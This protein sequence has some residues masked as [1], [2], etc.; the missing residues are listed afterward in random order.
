MS[1]MKSKILIL[2]IFLMVLWIIGIILHDVSDVG[3]RNKYTYHDFVFPVLLLGILFL[4]RS[5]QTNRRTSESSKKPSTLIYVLG[6]IACGAIFAFTCLF[7]SFFVLDQQAVKF[8]IPN[9]VFLC[10]VGS[11]ASIPIVRRYIK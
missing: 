6:C 9:M 8:I 3:L 10:I 2:L 11:L 4:M 7:L 5:I 1:Q